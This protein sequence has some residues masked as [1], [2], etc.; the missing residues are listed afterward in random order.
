MGQR[1]LYNTST[2][3]HLLP[4]C[5]KLQKSSGRNWGRGSGK[6]PLQ[7]LLACSGVHVL[8]YYS[9][10]LHM[11]ADTGSGIQ[12]W[13]QLQHRK[14]RHTRRREDRREKKEEA[15]IHTHVIIYIRIIL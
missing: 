9:Y 1:S 6:E 11:F 14:R 8:T 12:R 4:I 15:Y 13:S 3:I 5:F 2:D 10:Q 7:C